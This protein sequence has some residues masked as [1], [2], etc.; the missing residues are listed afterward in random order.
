MG[1]ICMCGIC[2]SIIFIAL[3]CR[4]TFKNEILVIGLL[5]II[6]VYACNVCKRE[7]EY[8]HK[9]FFSHTL[10]A[11][12]QLLPALSAVVIL[13]D[14]KNIKLV[15]MLYVQYPLCVYVTARGCVGRSVDYA[16]STREHHP[17]ECHSTQHNGVCRL[18]W[19]CF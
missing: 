14:S 18:G 9:L 4:D 7:R 11:C 2:K 5:E 19:V 17:F 3:C 10:Q 16:S 8:A 6:C 1:F 15:R 12:T 13:N